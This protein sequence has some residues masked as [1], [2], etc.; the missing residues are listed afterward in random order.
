MRSNATVGPPIELLFM[1]RDMLGKKDWYQDFEQDDPYLIELRDA[2]NAQIVQA[3]K[4]LPS[5]RGVF[6]DS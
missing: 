4:A 5:I 3:F 1:Q 2:W 6:S